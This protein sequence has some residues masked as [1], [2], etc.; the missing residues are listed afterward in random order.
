[1]YIQMAVLVL[2]TN[3]VLHS[4]LYR[5]IDIHTCVCKAIITT[6]KLLAAGAGNLSSTYH[7]ISYY[8]LTGEMSLQCG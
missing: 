5:Y 4:D 6:F 2:F 7:G 3:D 1:M 8:L